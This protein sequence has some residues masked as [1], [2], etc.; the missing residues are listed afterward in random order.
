MFLYYL[1]ETKK[2]KYA[3]FVSLIKLCIIIFFHLEKNF[4]KIFK[5]SR[6]TFYYMFYA[7]EIK[8]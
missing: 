2:K 7:Y 5:F 1:N 6:R 3:N 4:K 8:Y